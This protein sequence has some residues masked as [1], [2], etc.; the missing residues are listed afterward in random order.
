MKAND[1]PVKRLSIVLLRWRR[2][3]D[4]LS[5]LLHSC[6]NLDHFLDLDAQCIIII[7]SK[8]DTYY[9][10]D[11]ESNLNSCSGKDHFLAIPDF[12]VSWDAILSAGWLD[13]TGGV[14]PVVFPLDSLHYS[15]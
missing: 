12:L 7:G 1:S 9:N 6:T 10:C 15:F 3:C 2:Y 11:C 13:M 8:K 14:D 5:I 4:Q